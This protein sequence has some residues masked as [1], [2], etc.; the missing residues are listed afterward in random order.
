MIFDDS[1]AIFCFCHAAGCWTMF[2]LGEPV[3]LRFAWLRVVAQLLND[4]R[5]WSSRGTRAVWRR[6]LYV[7]WCSMATRHLTRHL[8]QHARGDSQQ[9][10][11]RRRLH[12]CGA[13]HCSGAVVRVVCV[14][15]CASSFAQSVLERCAVCALVRS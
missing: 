10:R 14:C 13:L 9:L 11:D 8:E 12:C 2:V 1:G 6:T 3:A 4:W 5:L 7:R 15:V